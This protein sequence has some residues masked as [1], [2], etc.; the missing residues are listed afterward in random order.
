MNY[1]D[2]KTRKNL[3]LAKGMRVEFEDAVAGHRVQTSLLCEPWH[4]K[5]DIGE[6]NVRCTM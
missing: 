6:V 2:Q 4:N 5:H 3:D 1:G